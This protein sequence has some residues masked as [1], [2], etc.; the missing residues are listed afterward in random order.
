MHTGRTK[1]LPIRWFNISSEN[2]KKLLTTFALAVAALT[3][4]A[5]EKLPPEFTLLTASELATACSVS[6]YAGADVFYHHAPLTP[7]TQATIL[8]LSFAAEVWQQDELDEEA[9]PRFIEARSDLTPEDATVQTLYCRD[10]AFQRGKLLKAE[11]T[12][13]LLA[14]TKSKAKLHFPLLFKE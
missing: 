12:Y 7:E 13:A 6:L 14:Q 5:A 9:I 8:R 3:A 4:S 2:M 10:V 1:T 11:D